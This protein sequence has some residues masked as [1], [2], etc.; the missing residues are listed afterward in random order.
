[1]KKII[2]AWCACLISLS[3]HAGMTWRAAPVAADR[4]PFLRGSEEQVMAAL[5]GDGAID[6]DKMWHGIHYLL[7]A[8]PGNRAMAELTIFGGEAVGADQGYGPARVLSPA[9]VKSIAAM[10]ERET[11]ATLAA[12]YAPAAMEAAHTYP[13]GIWIGEGREALMDLLQHYD[14]L[15]VFFKNAAIRGQAVVVL[16]G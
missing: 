12:R 16:L 10:L 3:A 6:L 14:V 1:M 15:L 5:E 7:A 4:I 2:L 9:Q 8:R 11:P 13:E